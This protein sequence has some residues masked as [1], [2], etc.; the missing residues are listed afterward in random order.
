MIKKCRVCLE[1]K[2]KE[3][4]PKNKN[5]ADGL[6]TICKACKKKQDKKNYDE[7]RSDPVKWE[8]EVKRTRDYKRF[9][10]TGFTSEMFDEKLLEQGNRCAICGTDDPGPT[11]W[12]ADH[13]HITNTPRGVLCK[14]CNTGIGMLQDNPKIVEAA[15]HYLNNHFT[16]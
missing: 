14:K 9:W 5:F 1:D 4:F 6:N 3:N 16:R 7:V 13:C 15:L 2:S 10:V 11:N 12:H 8:K